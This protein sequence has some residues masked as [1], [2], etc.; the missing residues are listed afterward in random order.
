[1]PANDFMLMAAY[2][3]FR[4]KGLS[5]VVSG[6]DKLKT[7]ASGALKA[8]GSLSSLLSGGFSALGAL[9]G[10]SSVMDFV[11]VAEQ[12]AM[13][14]RKLQVAL[15]AT[16]GS[17]RY[18]A[19]ELG[20][21]ATN[22]QRTTNFGD[23]TTVAAM[24]VLATFDKIQGD[25]FVQATKA[26]QDM[27]TFMGTD[28][29]SAMQTLGRALQDP[30]QGMMALR[31][32]GVM[33]TDQQKEQIKSLQESGDLLGAQNAIL[34]A[35]EGKYGG[36][37]EKMA[38]PFK[39]FENVLGDIGEA[40]GRWLTPALK[41]IVEVGE[42]ITWWFLENE[43]VI[44]EW[45]DKLGQAI[46]YVTDPIENFFYL[47]TEHSDVAWAYAWV[48]AQRF[49]DRIQD[50][51]TILGRVVYNWATSSIRGATEVLS[52]LPEITYAALF[53]SSAAA[54]AAM[55]KA[56]AAGRAAS[57]DIFAGVMEGT[58]EDSERTKEAQ[59]AFEAALQA[60]GVASM[61]ELLAR[62]TTPGV[63]EFLGRGGVA[64]GAK[65][66]ET[67]LAKAAQNFGEVTQVAF[68][69]LQ[70]HM[71][72]KEVRKAQERAAKAAEETADATKRIA[73][74]GVKITNPE[75]ILLGA[76]G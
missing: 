47:V 60:T 36:A 65:A 62:K 19:D 71:Q 30:E 46:A 24:G 26:A 38:S 28:L 66:A 55:V 74:K 68:N 23:D 8:A 5:G 63:E 45:A 6:M 25:T 2:T 42:S 40:V 64:A 61:D 31:R 10:V 9:A 32:A 18:T 16:G 14:T 58:G 69:R 27:A 17:V 50:G 51:F 44:Q 37:A 48:S 73:D 53:E 67:G 22:L 70:E 76:W 39:Q 13:A 35:V 34:A 1:M 29:D 33:L 41:E 20:K 54:S 21:L 15:D 52:A 7:A 57:D 59:K 11:K 3:E 49:L 12:D 43:G 72:A 56:I 75:D 4:E